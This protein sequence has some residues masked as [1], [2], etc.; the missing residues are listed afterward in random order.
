MSKSNIDTE[1]FV[2]NVKNAKTEELVFIAKLFSEKKK[3][4][5]IQVIISSALATV[6]GAAIFTAYLFPELSLTY[7]AIGSCIFGL[8]TVTISFWQHRKEEGKLLS[9]LIKENHKPTKNDLKIAEK[10][11][12]EIISASDA[13]K[14]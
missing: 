12:K 9:R 2:A 5:K 14:K 7:V 3:L 8:A 11:R 4:R 13:E 10:F 1:Q 6:A